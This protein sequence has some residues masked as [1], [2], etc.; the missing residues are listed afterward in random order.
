[1]LDRSQ[2]YKT[3]KMCLVCISSDSEVVELSRLEK[4]SPSKSRLTGWTRSVAVEGRSVMSAEG[5][6]LGGP[7]GDS[8]GVKKPVPVGSS[9]R[10]MVMEGKLEA[11]IK[12]VEALSK[13][14]RSAAA[15]LQMVSD[16]ERDL[17]VLREELSEHKMRFVGKF[18]DAFRDDPIFERFNVIET[19]VKDL[20][21][22]VAHAKMKELESRLHAAQCAQRETAE[23]NNSDISGIKSDVKDAKS[24]ISTTKDDVSSLHS[25]LDKALERIGELEARL[26][27]QNAT[28]AKKNYSSGPVMGSE[29]EAA[30]WAELDAMIG[31]DEIKAHMRL[32]MDQ[33][34]KRQTLVALLEKLETLAKNTRGYDDEDTVDLDSFE[35]LRAQELLPRMRKALDDLP[36]MHMVLT[37]SPGT[38]KTTV[39]RIVAK[40]LQHM[41]GEK[42]EF[43]VLRLADLKAKFLGQT[44]HLVREALTPSRGYTHLVVF[45]DEAYQLN[46]GRWCGDS[47]S[48]NQEIKA[49]FCEELE[50]NRGNKCVI[51]AGYTNEMRELMDSNP[52]L[53]SRFPNVFHCPDYNTDELY[54]IGSVL[55]E[56]NGHAF[57]EGAAE[58]FR[59]SI[60]ED[61]NGRDVRTLLE[62]AQRNAAAR[63]KTIDVD[64]SSIDA[65]LDYVETALMITV[66][67]MLTVKNPR[68]S[69]LYETDT[70]PSKMPGRGQSLNGDDNSLAI[71]RGRGRGKPSNGGKRNGK[72]N[73]SKIVGMA[74][75]HK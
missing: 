9:I 56:R 11:T 36:G 7:P 34:K 48:Y 62:R 32:Y 68:D 20:D 51:F 38:G 43:K 45:V 61:M 26:P 58:A 4:S 18:M 64:G 60:T 66:Q 24:N 19:Q 73:G 5:T 67:D 22:K 44:P 55:L 50:D 65:C 40:L 3:M 74:F 25:K 46:T 41:W 42:V 8:P 14:K 47:D 37:G 28:P 71:V 15:L 35:A 72:P 39:A 52:G 54:K 30:V 63:S 33:M 49:A 29:A 6:V 75:V 27:A 10:F 31:M 21:V 23:K 16:L 70:P 69:H 53:R 1:M 12:S 17:R 57:G 13:D 2:L 59:K